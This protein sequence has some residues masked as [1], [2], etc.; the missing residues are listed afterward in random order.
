MSGAALANA[1]PALLGAMAAEGA[2]AVGC[3]GLA[4]SLPGAGS[5]EEARSM[6]DRHPMG[7]LSVR[8][9]QE[10]FQWLAGFARQESVSAAAL[11]GHAVWLL[12]MWEETIKGTIMEVLDG[13]DALCREHDQELR[14]VRQHYERRLAGPARAGG[15]PVYRARVA[16]LLA[17]AVST[18][19]DGEAAAA[20]A[21]ARALH[22]QSA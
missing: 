11:T 19:S 21:K 5:A 2:P 9:R 17:L 10:D 8:L 15:A 3:L 7:R 14:Q 18:D 12:R 6:G 22:H 16:R 1:A 4:A 13:I 20:L